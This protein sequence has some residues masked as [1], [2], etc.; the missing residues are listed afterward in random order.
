MTAVPTR[1][2]VRRN[3]A[4]IRSAQTRAAWILVIPFL[5]IFAAFFIVWARM[6]PVVVPP[7]PDD[8]G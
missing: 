2:A 1:A 3:P 5:L 7:D 6:R 8:E 4:R